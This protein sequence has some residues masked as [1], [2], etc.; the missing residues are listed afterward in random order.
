MICLRR[1]LS[2]LAWLTGAAWAAPGAAV[3][4]P[5]W[6]LGVG[7]AGLR[8]PHYRG[9]DQSHNWLLPVPYVV[10]RGEIFKADRDGARAT[11]FESDRVDIDLSLAAGAPTYSR[12]NRAR[13][14]MADL[15]PSF[16]IGPN[17]NLNLARGT[18][19][20]LDL[21]APLRAALTFQSKPRTIG[22]I[23]TPNLN[24]DVTRLQ[25]W[26]LGLQAGAVFASRRFN[27][28]FYDVSPADAT[29]QR[30][31]YSAAGGFGGGQ[32]TAALSRRVEN[33]WMGFFVKLDSL[34]GARFVDSPLVRQR[35]NVA[36]GFAVSW[37]LRTSAD[38]V[39]V[40][41]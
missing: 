11:L 23:A 37:V 22:W 3:E 5:L 28:H 32:L 33:R 17:L 24:L 21:R 36:L 20:K 39:S 16:E 15:A 34:Q 27:A 6:E 19:W 1:G 38:T 9:S 25:G 8:M 18:G 40:P 29:T 4:R 2:T 31:A 26:N 10:Y 41:E 13:Q 14:G 35:T 7:V 12:N 30:P